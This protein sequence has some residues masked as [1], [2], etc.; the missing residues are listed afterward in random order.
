[1]NSPRS[2]TDGCPCGIL[3]I[4]SGPSGVG[5]DSVLRRALPRLGSIRTSISVTTR[6]PRPTERDGVDYIFV[7]PE[8]FRTMQQ[9][10]QL[11]EYA[12][13][14]N[15]CYG[16]P[17]EWVFTQLQAG[18][19][20]VLEIDVQ[21]AVQVRAHFPDAILIFLAPPNW[22]ELARRLRKRG[23]EDEAT[24]RRRLDNARHE[25]AR[26]HDYEYLIIND[27]IN[28]A[29]DRLCAVVLAERARPWRQNLRHLLSEEISNE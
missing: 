29:T 26:V 1:M 20:V 27:D 23:T 9:H 7:A 25:L 12:D 5:K 24:I 4:L 16:T 22:S 2:Q 15:H 19:D 13:V 3:F 18:T 14:H 28:E 17:R 10:D 6:A 8:A 21:G 11:L